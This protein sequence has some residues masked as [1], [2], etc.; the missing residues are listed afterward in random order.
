MNTLNLHN[1][2]NV[3]LGPV[4]SVAV[5]GTMVH[6]RTLYVETA[7]GPVQVTMYAETNNVQIN[8]EDSP[9]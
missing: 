8:V 7:T 1:V 5:D 2:T 4:H 3:K 9:R 6:Y